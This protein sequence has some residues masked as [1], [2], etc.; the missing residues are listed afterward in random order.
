MT[1]K[2]IRR[3]FHIFQLFTRPLNAFLLRLRFR[4]IRCKR[5]QTSSAGLRLA[6]PRSATH[7]LTFPQSNLGNGR[8]RRGKASFLCS[9]LALQLVHW[10]Q[11]LTINYLAY[12]FNPL[13]IRPSFC[14]EFFKQ[15]ADEEVDMFR[16]TGQPVHGKVAAQPS[17][18]I[19]RCVQLNLLREQYM[20]P[21][22]NN[23]NVSPPWGNAHSGNCV[24]TPFWLV[25]DLA[26]KCLRHV[27]CVR[28]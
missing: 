19:C 4:V 21:Y 27:G 13:L 11:S 15:K 24:T 16:H 23:D 12:V 5:R 25:V 10:Y 17:N 26:L 28:V 20:C 9:F 8:R 14:G 2:R 18:N 3:H 1:R 22:D 7:R 6:A